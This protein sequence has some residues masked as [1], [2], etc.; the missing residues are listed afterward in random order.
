MPNLK[1]NI[2]SPLQYISAGQF[3]SETPWTHARRN[4][5][6]FELI[7]GVRK[8]L[9]IQEENHP[10]QVGPGDVLLLCPHRTH[11]GYAEC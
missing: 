1:I 9:Y 11:F 3:Q 2:R 8:I 4:I 10:F 5:D 6:S 7:V